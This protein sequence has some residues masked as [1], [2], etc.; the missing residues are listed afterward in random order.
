LYNQRILRE[1]AEISASK[2]IVSEAAT[3][4]FAILIKKITVKLDSH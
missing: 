1:P 2:M 3:I 4:S